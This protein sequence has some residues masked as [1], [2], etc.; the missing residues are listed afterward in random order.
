MRLVA[1]PR[2]PVLQVAL[3]VG[4]S[5]TEAF[6]RAFK[7][8]FGTTPTGWRES[9]LS[10]RDQLKSKLDQARAQLPSNHGYMKVTIVER[11]PTPI[12]Y[13][14]HVGP[15]GQPVSE[16]WMKKVAPWME[17][18]GLYGR[19]RYGISHADPGITA[20]QSLRYDAAVEVPDGFV[21]AGDHQKRSFR[22][23]ST[24]SAASRAPTSGSA[25]RGHGCCATGCRTAAYNST[26][27]RSSSTTRS[28][29]RMT[30]RQANSN[31]RSAYRSRR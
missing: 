17:M 13:L 28:R 31:A 15:Y 20:P 27:A 1:Q 22:K 14:R 6:A 16:F 18:N 11:H 4:F 8:R 5:S 26:R 29:R 21:G 12:A 7:A 10:N 25:M 2:L 19:P 9:Q 23:A 24:R 3:S 30:A